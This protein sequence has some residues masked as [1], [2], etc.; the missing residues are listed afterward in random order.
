MDEFEAEGSF[1]SLMHQLR[2]ELGHLG[3]HVDHMTIVGAHVPTEED[4]EPV[5][6]DYDLTTDEIVGK[7]KTGDGQFGIALRARL[8]DLAWDDRTLEPEKFQEQR[9]ADVLMPSM[10][11]MIKSEMERQLAEGIAPE[12]VVIP[13]MFKL[14]LDTGDEDEVPDDES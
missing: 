13:D 11:E 7:I 6:D 3:V 5:P 8:G 14:G 1:N 12:D 10:E 2:E 4:D 9:T